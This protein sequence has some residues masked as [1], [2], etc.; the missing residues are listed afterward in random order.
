M[1]AYHNYRAVK[2]FLL[3]GR[4]YDISTAK[5][6]AEPPKS[7]VLPRKR[8]S[9]AAGTSSAAGSSTAVGSSSIAGSSSAVINPAPEANASESSSSAKKDPKSKK[10]LHS[11]R[12]KTPSK[13]TPKFPKPDTPHSLATAKFRLLRR[14]YQTG[15]LTIGSVQGSMT[16][17]MKELAILDEVK[18]ERLRSRLND[19]VLVI[20]EIQR[21]AYWVVA[22]FIDKVLRE[23][24]DTV[25]GK[26]TRKELLD[27]LLDKP[28]FLF[29]MGNL[30]YNGKTRS[31]DEKSRFEE[32]VR[33]FHDLTGL[34]PIMDMIS[35]H[36]IGSIS[37]ISEMAMVSVRAALK[38]CAYIYMFT[39]HTI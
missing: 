5:E 23:P 13:S 33:D 18:V 32:A 15:T 11:G 37:R 27:G 12:D 36:K 39:V 7:V 9:S 20:N 30:L 14:I 21:R 19:A 6:H 3:A 4:K 25:E 31:K 8:P 17:R 1:H 38:S 24:V 29:N 28:N 34:P 35:G 16:R 10:G 2:K 22:L 26:K